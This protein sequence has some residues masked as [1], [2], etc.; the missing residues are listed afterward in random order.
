MNEFDR[1]GGEIGGTARRLTGVRSEQHE[2]RA[3]P[4][5]ASFDQMGRRLGDKRMFG[6]P[7]DLE[8]QSLDARHVPAQPRGKGRMP[9]TSHLF[10]YHLDAVAAQAGRAELYEVNA[11][12]VAEADGTAGN[13]D[14]LG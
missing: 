9:G 12:V 3:Q 5:A 7:G 13:G 6:S 2:G 14:H 8:E 1:G 10:A 11:L 4:L